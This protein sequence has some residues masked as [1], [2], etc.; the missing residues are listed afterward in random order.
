MQSAHALGVGSA[1]QPAD[2]ADG[3]RPPLIGQALVG[4]RQPRLPL[5]DRAH[6]TVVHSS[7]RDAVMSPLPS[8]T[9][10]SRHAIG[11]A[12]S[13]AG[14]TGATAV[15]PEHLL[16]APLKEPTQDAVEARLDAEEAARPRHLLRA[17]MADSDS[18]AARSLLALGVRQASLVAWP[19]WLL[20][21]CGAAQTLGSPL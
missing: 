17:L 6:R 14:R 11:I 20:P 2:A 15:A 18:S 9:D 4:A 13:T 10:A 7:I 19:Q 12:I 1:A 8:L 21:G 16:I 3:L 5:C